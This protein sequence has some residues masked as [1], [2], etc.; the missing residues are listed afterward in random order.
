NVYL[1]Q[2]APLPRHAWLVPADG[3][4]PT[5][6]TSGERSV[7]ALG[8]TPD[9]KSLAIRTQ[10][11]PH[12]GEGIRSEVSVRDMETGAE[13]ALAKAPAVFGSF[14]ISPNGRF[15]AWQ[16]ARGPELGFRPNGGYVMPLAGGEPRLVTAGLDRAVQGLAWLPDNASLL[17]QAPDATRIGVWLQPV[18]GSARRLDWGA[19]DPVS[20]FHLSPAG[21]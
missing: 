14:A 2:A 7:N 20:E 1:A 16:R 15:I 3:G 10:P 12:S 4:K 18:E 6:I 13:R 5:R 11:R 9:G 8:W 19:I 17:I 21:G